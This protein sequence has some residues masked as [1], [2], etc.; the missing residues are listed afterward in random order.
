M[1][2][3]TPLRCYQPELGKVGTKCVNQLSPLAD[4]EISRPMQHQRALLLDVLDWHKTHR[5]PRHGLADRRRI[6]S[7]VLAALHIGFDIGRR[8]E[9]CVMPHLVELA[10]PLM[11]RCGTLPCQ[12]GKV[13]ERQRTQEL[14]LDQH[15]CGLPPCLLHRRRE[16]E[17]PTSQYRPRLC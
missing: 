6:G 13:A 4:Q 5:W 17:T 14:S 7:I 8:H 11:R 15:A 16:S 9:P 10:C 1:Q 3:F 12:R 2:S